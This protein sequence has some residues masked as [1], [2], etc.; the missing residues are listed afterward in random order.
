MFCSAAILLGLAT[1]AISQL[2]SQ[3]VDEIVNTATAEWNVGGQR[4]SKSSNEVRFNVDRTS[5]QPVISLFHYTNASGGITANIPATTCQSSTGPMPVELTGAYSGFDNNAASIKPTT[6]I[7]AGE[8][9]IIQL[10]LAARNIHPNSIDSF[11]IVIITEEGD[12]EQIR[13]SET[14]VNSGIFMGHIITSAIPPTPTKN[15]C[16]LSVVP[17]SNLTISIDDSSSGNGLGNVN[18]DILIDPFGTSFDSGDGSAVDGTRVS[19]VDAVTGQPADV[20]GDDGISTFP[21][22]LITGST[23]TDASGQVYNFPPGFYRFPFLRPGRYRLVIEPPAP[24]SAPSNATASQL[25]ALLDADGQPYDISD[26]S[27]G[28]EFT[29][30]DPAPVRIDIP[31]DKPGLPLIISKTSSTVTAM[32]GDVIQYRITVKNSDNV[33]NT[34]TITIK[35]ILPSS[36]RYN[37][38]TMRYNGVLITPQIAANGKS[39]T[40][41]VP[42]LAAGQSGL[43]TYLAEVRQDAQPGDA[44][45]LASASDGFG[46]TSGTTDSTVRIIRDG[47]SERFTIIGRL[48]DGGCGVDPKKANGIANVRVMMEDGRYTVTDNDGQYHF[49]GVQPGIHVVQIDPYSLPEGFTPTDCTQNTRSA[50]SA[51]SRFVEGQGGGLKRADFVA[52]SDGRVLP[53]TAKNN[54]QEKNARPAPASKQADNAGRN[55]ANNMRHDARAVS[56]PLSVPEIKTAKADEDK[57]EEINWFAGQTSGVAWVFPEENHN[58]R[59]KAIRAVVKHL[60]GQKVEMIVNG[61]KANPLNYDG[62]KKSPDGTVHISTWRSLPLQEGENILTAIVR[63]ADGSEAERL[64]RKVHYSTAP[65]FAQLVKEKSV[66]VADGVTRPVIAVRLTDRS[67]RPIQPESVGA[68]KV[69]AP[70]FPA[71][72]VDAQQ[73]NQL[74]GLERGAPVW[75]VRGDNGIAYIE[76]EPTMASGSVSIDFDFKDGEVSRMQHIEAWLGA[77]DRPW[78]IVGFAAGTIGFNKLDSGLQ[79]LDNEDNPIHLDGRIALYAKG[80]VSGEWLMTMSY[81]SD[82]DKDETRFAGVIDPRSYYTVYADRSEQRYDA[83]SIRHL[84]L[85]LERPQFYAL[86]GDY[87]TAINEPELARYQRSFNGIKAEYRNDRVAATVFGADTPYQFRREEIQGNGLSGPYALASRDIISNSEKI[88]I[89]TRDRLRDDKIIESKS[90]VRHIDYDIDYLAG[91]ISFREPILSR[92]SGLDPQ[93]IIAEYEVDGIGQRVINAGGR[94][95]WNDSQNKLQIGATLIHDESDVET[96]NMAGADIIY[97]LDAQTQISAEFAHSDS[98]ADTNSGQTDRGSATAWLIEAEHHSKI[99]DILAYIRKQGTGF[100]VG[101]NNV[102]LQGTRKYGADARLRLSDKLQLSVVG[103]REEFLENDTRRLAG[104]MELEYRNAISSLAAGLTHANDRLSDGSINKSTIAKLGGSH[105]FLNGKLELNAQTEFALGGQDESIDFP[106]RHQIGARYAINNDIAL[107]A[108]YEIAKGENID[109]RTLRAGFDVA[110]WSGAR[111]TASANQ[112]DIAEYGARSFAAYGLKQ[113]FKLDDKWSLDFTIDGNQTLGGINNADILNEAQPVA[114]GGFLGSN[115]SITEDF[116]ALTGGATYRSDNWSWTSRAEFRDGAE[117]DRYGLTTAFIRQ[118]QDGITAAGQFSWYDAK[119]ENGASTSLAEAELSFAYRPFDSDWSFLN[120]MEIRQDKVRG[121]TAGQSGPIGGAA[122]LVNG[123][124][125]SRRVINS[126]SVNYS[127]TLE[128]SLLNGGSLF[129]E[130]SEF[131]LFWGTRYVFDK[132]GADDVEGWSN[133]IGGDMHFDISKHADIGLS[134]NV[135]IGQNARNFA[136]SVGPTITVAPVTN[137]NVT[138]GY[139]IVGF[140]DRDFEESRY[141]RSGPFITLKLKFD[142]ESLAGFKL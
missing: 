52:V 129:L 56:P 71:V 84:Y 107:V 23:V 110:P 122:L 21:N 68:F 65:I 61:T 46:S 117:V 19:I 63:N 88:T 15:N 27:Y 111:L 140:E 115:N 16:I 108:G 3:P 141:T 126:L 81:D 103:Y 9:L 123:D 36:L 30:F 47:I 39:F 66:L 128:K 25:A 12:E 70:H 72:E 114:S 96:T 8:P 92:S 119:Q 136:Y 76:L 133:V 53:K 74:S 109:A 60:P 75:R 40:V 7:R 57:N 106:A 99:V 28:L 42:S 93:F 22:V 32:P 113:S 26:G 91:T 77:G 10:A 82:K 139:N 83:A 104:S 116:L 31:L 17:G 102:G 43:L 37:I 34:A 59:I 134:G 105:K 11:N 1:P 38:G 18:V 2:N 90:L 130:R 94:V 138:L 121:A 80:K 35:D 101:Q 79:N 120:K 89:E 6:S 125:T 124:A 41:D 50:G 20:F 100:G 69:S 98:K 135:R 48:T 132:F 54:D 97:H 137:M 95:R 29:L 13:I 87:E 86:F 55:E 4:L 14:D 64:E 112:Q 58:P 127:P 5:A 24:Y 49:E 78:T 62:L 85:K 67:G 51:I 45:N 118:I 131:N 33:R 44:I 73:A 142:Q